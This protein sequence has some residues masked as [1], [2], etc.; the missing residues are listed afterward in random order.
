MNMHL[1]PV[2]KIENGQYI[3]YGP[4]PN[5]VTPTNRTKVW[6]GI[7]E[8]GTNYV[9]MAVRFGGLADV[10]GPLGKFCHN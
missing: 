2:G 8:P 1:T 7:Y 5:L 9:V 10:Q 6:F 3:E 4:K